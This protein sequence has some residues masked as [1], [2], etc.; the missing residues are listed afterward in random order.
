MGGRTTMPMAASATTTPTMLQRSQAGPQGTT[1][2][3]P[4]SVANS[5]I[6]EKTPRHRQ[7]RVTIGDSRCRSSGASP[8]SGSAAGGTSG[9]GAGDPEPPAGATG[10]A[11]LADSGAGSS[12]AGLVCSV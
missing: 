9:D 6:T 8:A 4:T 1:I 11:G 7:Y 3:R 10:I 12:P 5:G 2:A